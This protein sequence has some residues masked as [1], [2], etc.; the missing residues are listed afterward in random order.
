M[1]LNR[2]LENDAA[3][4][5]A[6]PVLTEESI[7]DF[8]PRYAMT[9]H[10]ICMQPFI[11]DGS[12]LAFSQ[13]DRLKAGDVAVIFWQPGKNNPGSFQ[14]Q[15]KQILVPKAKAGSFV[16]RLFRPYQVRE[17]RLEDVIGMHKCIGYRRPDGSIHEVDFGRMLSQ[18]EFVRAS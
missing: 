3:I 5:A 9:V 15:V 17:G 6:Q 11:K 4:A 14:A 7:A 1:G 2:S 10:G 18:C 16:Y 13:V 12:N 8:P